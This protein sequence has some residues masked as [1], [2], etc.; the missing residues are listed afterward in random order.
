MNGYKIS[1]LRNPKIWPIKF[2]DL[3]QLDYYIR[4]I[5]KIE[6]IVYAHNT[7]YSKLLHIKKEVGPPDSGI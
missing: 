5:V 7:K 1:W 2:P 3:I 4:S 6:D